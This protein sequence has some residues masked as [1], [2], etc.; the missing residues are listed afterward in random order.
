VNNLPSLS[1]AATAILRA[2][3]LTAGDVTDM[4]NASRGNFGGRGFIDNIKNGSHVVF[5]QVDL[6]GVKSV[7]PAIT[8]FGDVAGGSVE[9]RL[10]SLDGKVIGSTD[11]KNAA[12]TKV[13]D[14]VESLSQRIPVGALSGKQD[15]YLVFKNPSAGDKKLFIFSQLGLSNK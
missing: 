10:G 5:G 14:G 9:V 7:T 12:R 15:L 1:A 3:V 11:F 8:L 6:T 4:N 13:A 2:P